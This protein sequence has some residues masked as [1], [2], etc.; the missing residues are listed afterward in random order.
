MDNLNLNEVK[1]YHLYILNYIIQYSIFVLN[2]RKQ[3]RSEVNDNNKLHLL[4]KHR[5]CVR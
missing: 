1:L 2:Y 5:I 3:E 4:P